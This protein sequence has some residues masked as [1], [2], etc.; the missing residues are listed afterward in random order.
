M[1]IYSLPKL[2]KRFRPYGLVNVKNVKSSCLPFSARFRNYKGTTVW[3][4]MAAIARKSLPSTRKFNMAYTA[5]VTCVSPLD[6]YR[7]NATFWLYTVPSTLSTK[8]RYT[9]FERLCI[10]KV[11][12]WGPST[13]IASAGE[14]NV[15][16]TLTPA[17]P[18]RT[19]K[20]T[21]PDEGFGS[22]SKEWSGRVRNSSRAS[23]W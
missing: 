7:T 1:L 9:P 8:I 4:P 14:P 21:A 5:L 15:V 16:N 11:S 2:K 22:I 23:H 3:H 12:S 6:C 20:R 18:S 17:I 13:R 10:P 19:R